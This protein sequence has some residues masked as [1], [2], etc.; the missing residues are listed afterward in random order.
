MHGPCLISAPNVAFLIKLQVRSVHCQPRSD[1]TIP[2]P[3]QHDLAIIYFNDRRTITDLGI[4]KSALPEDE[5]VVALCI[6]PD[7]KRQ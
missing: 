4:T 7:G 5:S 2:D 1:A 3:P 6:S